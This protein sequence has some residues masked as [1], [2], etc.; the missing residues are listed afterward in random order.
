MR[1]AIPGRRW[2]KSLPASRRCP[3]MAR[4][5]WSPTSARAGP[6]GGAAAMAWTACSGARTSWAPRCRWTA[7]TA[8]PAW[9]WTFPMRSRRRRATLQLDQVAR[10][11]LEHRLAA[12]V[13]LQLAVDALDVVRHRHLRQ[14]QVLGDLVV[15][16]ALGDAPQD[17]D[18]AAG[19]ADAVRLALR[20]L[21]A[22]FLAGGHG[23]CPG[24]VGLHP[25][26]QVARDGGRQ[27]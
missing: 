3:A 17:V 19:Q 12:A 16:H 25:A 18:L 8:G 21:V 1:C 23:R 13:D 15:G 9:C 14:A 6:R 20:D 2:W 22:L 7:M 5:R 24:V 26:Q 11:R 10:K 4:G 27:R